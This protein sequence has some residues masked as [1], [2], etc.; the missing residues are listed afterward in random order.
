M[1]PRKT[2]RPARMT[3]ESRTSTAN[4]KAAI[5]IRFTISRIKL[6]MPLESTSETELT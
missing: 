5:K 6:I 3:S 4:M 2:G 1:M